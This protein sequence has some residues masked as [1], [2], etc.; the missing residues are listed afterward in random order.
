MVSEANTV[1]SVVYPNPTQG[2]VTIEAENLQSISIFNML[3]EI[4]LETSTNGD[5]FEYDFNHEKAGI[6][7]VKVKTTKGTETMKVTVR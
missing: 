6:Y 2:K 3:G 5:V 1:G 4:I 7:F